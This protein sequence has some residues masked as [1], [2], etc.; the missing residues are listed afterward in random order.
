M[1]ADLCSGEKEGPDQAVRYN[2]SIVVSSDISNEA[3]V[4]EMVDVCQIACEKH[5]AA[6][7]SP[8]ERNNVA[9]ANMIKG[10][11]GRSR[12]VSQKESSTGWSLWSVVRLTMICGAP[13]TYPLAQ[14]VLPNPQRRT[15]QKEKQPKSKSKSTQLSDHMDHPVSDI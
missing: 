15:R 6:E 1:S 10:R 11:E 9:A 2:Y 5:A 7:K 12:T 4:K 13:P 8:S 3:V 14:P